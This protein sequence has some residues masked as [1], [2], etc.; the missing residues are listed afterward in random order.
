[1]PRSASGNQNIMAKNTSSIRQGV[2]THLGTHPVETSIP[3]KCEMKKSETSPTFSTISKNVRGDNLLFSIILTK[4]IIFF[5]SIFQESSKSKN[6]E[7]KFNLFLIIFLF[8]EKISHFAF[9]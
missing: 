1:M 9:A 4:T 2:G 7:G 5:F 6:K 8:I 3:G